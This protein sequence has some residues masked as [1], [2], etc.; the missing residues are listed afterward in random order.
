MVLIAIAT[1]I[2]RTPSL[3][4]IAYLTLSLSRWSTL[5]FRLCNVPSSY[6]ECCTLC[7]CST[8]AGPK[9]EDPMFEVCRVVTLTHGSVGIIILIW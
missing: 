5:V 7:R 8:F 2:S 1:V 4:L 6:L 9:L 3:R